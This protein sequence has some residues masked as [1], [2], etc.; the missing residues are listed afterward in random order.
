MY[1]IKIDSL[2][3]LGVNYFAGNGG[4]QGTY[5]RATHISYAKTY[6]TENGAIG[7]VT[8]L[9][10]RT[11]RLSHITRSIEV[12]AT[13]MQMVS[14]GTGR[15]NIQDAFPQLNADER[16]FIKSGITAS[17]WEDAF[18]EDDEE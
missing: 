2:D 11:S 1:V 13:E 5:Q 12:D 6:K 4:S 15:L 7:Q 16:E 17:E 9:L 14:Y 18:A 3:G 10:T 8:K